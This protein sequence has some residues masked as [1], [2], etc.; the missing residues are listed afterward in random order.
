MKWSFRREKRKQ[1]VSI[2]KAR[3]HRM[4]KSSLR[5]LDEGQMLFSDWRYLKTVHEVHIVNAAFSKKPGRL[6]ITLYLYVDIV[7]QQM[8]MSVRL[9]LNIVAVYQLLWI[10]IDSY[11]ST[12]DLVIQRFVQRSLLSLRPAQSDNKLSI[13]CSMFCCCFT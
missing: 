4:M 3:L 5:R 8:K 10:S 11:F 12:T 6:T 7:I 13:T 2:G 9:K 1:N